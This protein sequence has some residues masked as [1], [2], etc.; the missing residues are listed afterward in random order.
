VVCGW[1]GAQLKKRKSTF[2]GILSSD[3][4]ENPAFYNWNKVM[5]FYCDGGVRG[6]PHGAAPTTPPSPSTSTASGSSSPSC[7]V[8]GTCCW[9][10]LP[11]VV[12]GGI[13]SM[14]QSMLVTAPVCVHFCA[15]GHAY[16]PVTLLLC[17]LAACLPPRGPG[18]CWPLFPLP[19]VVL[20]LCLEI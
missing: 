8:R 14:R 17:H 16:G 2:S 1:W 19:L 9:C 15:A 13:T 6:E 3:A 12:P 10:Y 18:C 11:L 5:V 4:A 7:M 20:I